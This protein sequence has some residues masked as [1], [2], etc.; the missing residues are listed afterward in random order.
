MRNFT[1][2][3]LLLLLATVGVLTS[4]AQGGGTI[5]PQDMTE[6][7]S[8]ITLKTIRALFPDQ[9]V[10]VANELFGGLHSVNDVDS[11]HG[12]S[13][14][15]DAE[16]QV[17]MLVY[18]ASTNMYYRYKGEDA[19]GKNHNTQ[20]AST[21][22]DVLDA[23]GVNTNYWES[24]AD[25]IAAVTDVDSVYAA[26]NGDLRTDDDNMVGDVFIADD[27]TYIWDGSNWQLMS[28][29]DVDSVLSNRL[30]FAAP[31]MGD[32]A[33]EE[34]TTWIY[35]GSQWQSIATEPIDVNVMND[36]TG[37]GANLNA[38]DL[39]LAG[40]TTFV[41]DGSDWQ[42]LALNEGD[43]VFSQDK[44]SLSD[45]TV[46]DLV[47]NGDSIYVWDGDDWTLISV[48]P[49]AAKDSFIVY[50]DSVSADNPLPW[51]GKAV[52]QEDFRAL[53]QANNASVSGEDGVV[54]YYPAVWGDFT[55][56]LGYPLVDPNLKLEL[57]NGISVSTVDPA[58]GPQDAELYKK[59]TIS[60]R[61]AL[62]YID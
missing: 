5:A 7:N 62:V 41:Y 20:S 30:G 10:A 22:P 24:L 50:V 48:L 16:L 61:T 27:T 44:E 54:L 36:T 35:D 60:S 25:I 19:D 13:Y 8:S 6:A 52:S 40:D 43:S 31:E 15:D 32:V 2:L 56:S 3:H 1:R 34:D 47:N 46:G 55:Y 51:L 39:Y 49:S 26:F 29:F 33:V 57:T 9:P 17:G 21:V 18:V 4:Y 12:G 58:S 28:F 14:L 23:D 11:L 42:T 53:I 37:V 38:G 45:N 59:V